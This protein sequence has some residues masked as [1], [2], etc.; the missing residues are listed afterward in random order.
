[1]KFLRLETSGFEKVPKGPTDNKLFK[2]VFK[3]G[4]IAFKFNQFY[5]Y[6]TYLNKAVMVSS[7]PDSNTNSN[8][9]TVAPQT[10]AKKPRQ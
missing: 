10:A 3:F 4:N 1:M 8:L 2:I 7:P 9:K 5:V 6:L